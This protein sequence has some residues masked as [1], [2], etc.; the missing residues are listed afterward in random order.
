MNAWCSAPAAALTAPGGP[1]TLS[2]GSDDGLLKG[3][4]LE[5]FR[6]NPARYLGTVRVIQVAPHQ[7]V[8]Q[9][10]SRPL[11]PIQQGDKVASKI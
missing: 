2:V 3:H 11:G 7:A 8:A 9:P 6:L 1:L 4:T 10:V 5:V